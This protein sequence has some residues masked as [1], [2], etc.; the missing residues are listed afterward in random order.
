MCFPTLCTCANL[1]LPA[2]SEN[3][4]NN[5]AAKLTSLLFL[6][7]VDAIQTKGALCFGTKD[8][9]CV[10]TKDRKAALVLQRIL[11]AAAL[12][13]GETGLVYTHSH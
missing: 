3:R 6:L 8:V 9:L 12:G 4:E 13:K 10:G 11:T 1:L 2:H 7:L 5:L